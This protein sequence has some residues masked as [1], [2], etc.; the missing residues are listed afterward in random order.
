M[1]F[2]KTDW[3]RGYPTGTSYRD[4]LF[5]GDF[6]WG[7]QQEVT[8]RKWRNKL[9]KTNW[10]RRSSALVGQRREP[11]P[12][13]SPHQAGFHTTKRKKLRQQPVS[14]PLNAHAVHLPDELILQVSD[15]Q[16]LR[17]ILR[18][19]AVQTTSHQHQHAS[20]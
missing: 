13:K 8:R 5:L 15:H 16:M 3:L 11:N 7:E 2:V 10:M 14:N 9:L 6:L 1:Y 4:A 19:L 18:C 12:K 20:G 17:S